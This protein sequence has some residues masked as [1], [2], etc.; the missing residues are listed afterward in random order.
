MNTDPSTTF[1]AYVNY[2]D[3]HNEPIFL[4]HQLS[5]TCGQDGSVPETLARLLRNAKSAGRKLWPSRAHR[6]SVYIESQ[7]DTFHMCEQGA[8]RS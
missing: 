7:T 2:Y 1:R 4:P 8:K 5:L 6:M 3:K